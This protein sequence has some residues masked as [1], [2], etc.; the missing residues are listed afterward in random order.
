MY[1]QSYI[2]EKSKNVNLSIKKAG[3]RHDLTQKFENRPKLT[4]KFKNSSR[5]EMFDLCFD[6]TRSI[7]WMLFDPKSTVENTPFAEFF[8]RNI[9]ETVV[10]INSSI[11][12]KHSRTKIRQ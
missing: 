10:G 12:S 2:P 6:R 7:I 11:K 4:Q 1:K 3:S 9:V 8:F 5:V